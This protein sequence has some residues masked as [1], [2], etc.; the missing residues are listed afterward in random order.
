M[1]Y[2]SEVAKILGVEIGEEFN[3]EGGSKDAKY[4]FSKDYL[5]M[6]ITD[7]GWTRASFYLV[8]LLNG[9][10]KIVKL[11]KSILTEKEKEYLSAVIKPF[12][13][14]IKYICKNNN[15]DGDTEFLDVQLDGNDFMAFPNFKKGTM[16]KGMELNKEYTIKDLGL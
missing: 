11:P 16:Y 12:R 3:I 7:V 13:N 1:N 10:L 9:K 5:I 2:M 14:R 4:K 6:E 8:D 15:E